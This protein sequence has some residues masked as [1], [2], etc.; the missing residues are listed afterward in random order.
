MQALVSLTKMP[1]R[2]EDSTG[3][4][5]ERIGHKIAGRPRCAF[6]HH[7]RAPSTPSILLRLRRLS[8]WQLHL[9]HQLDPRDFGRL[10]H[11]NAHILQQSGVALERRV[12]VAHDVGGP[13]VLG[14]VGVAG[15]DEF[16]LEGF[17]LLLGAEFVGLKRTE[18]VDVVSDR[19]LGKLTMFADCVR[20][21]LEFEGV[22][23]EVKS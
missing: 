14:G 4:W 16:A 9:L 12:R 15:A 21:V 20:E 23:V 19:G 6:R 3:Q 17:E 11:S 5:F 18:L 2:R 7:R 10:A 13:F 8:H 1:D 22:V